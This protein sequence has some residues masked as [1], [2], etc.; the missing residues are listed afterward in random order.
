MRRAIALALVASALLAS[1]ATAAPP[2]VTPIVTGQPGDGGWYVGN[3]IV[4]WSITPP[5]YLVDFGCAAATSI[6]TDTTGTKVECQASIG[7]DTAYSSVTIRYRFG[8]MRTLLPL[9][10]QKI[11]YSCGSP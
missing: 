4:N 2:T 1:G 8:S 10:S 3:V 9:K 11:M 6:T 7:G 5:G